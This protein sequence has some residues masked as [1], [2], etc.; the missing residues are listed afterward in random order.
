MPDDNEFDR[1]QTE[2]PSINRRGEDV[3]K[4][5]QEAGRHDTGTQGATERMAGTSTSRDFTSVDPQRRTS[6]DDEERS[7]AG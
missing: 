6:H 2:V 4:E 5:E 1:S 3:A 7:P